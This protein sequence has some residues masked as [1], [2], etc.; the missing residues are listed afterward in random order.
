MDRKLIYW[1]LLAGGLAACSSPKEDIIRLNQVGYFPLQEKVAVADKVGV[2]DFRVVNAA[3]GEEIMEQPTYAAAPCA[4]SQKGR[5]TIDFSSLTEPGRYLLLAGGDTAVFEIKERPLASLA[6]ASLKAFYYQRAGMPIEET[7][8]GEWARPA[9][10]A[11]AEVQIHSSAESP[12]RKAGDVIASA[13]GWYDGSDYAKCVVSTAYSAGTML[14]AYR[15]FPDYFAG[16]NI[17]IPE[18]GNAT[19]D[20]LDEAHYALNWM[21]TMQDPGDGGVYHKLT[22]P[23]PE[24]FVKPSDC[25]QPRYIV[26]KSQAASLDF[27]AVM[28]QAALIFK[29]YAKDYPGFANTA[30]RAAE[31]AYKWAQDHAE[32][33]EQ[34]V[35]NANFDPDIT[36]A[37]YEDSETADEFFWAASELYYA[38][39]KEAYRNKAISSAKSGYNV[40]NWKDVTA[41]GIWAWLLPERENKL[42]VAETSLA[43][44]LKSYLLAYAGDIIKG[45]DETAFHAPYGDDEYDFFRGSL[46]ELCVGQGLSLAYAYLLSKDKKYLTNAYRNMD[47]LLGRNPLGYCYVTGFGTKSP[48]HPSHRLSATDGIDAPIPGFLVGGPN[49]SQNDAG[50]AHAS[51]LP[52]EAYSDAEA[53]AASN[54]VAIAWNAGLAALASALDAMSGE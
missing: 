49:P 38:T 33:Y 25:K 17:H 11:D 41:L 5:S 20:L 39:G 18:S 52:D 43:G 8:A 6:D 44:S 2:T 9:G 23:K 34:S 31:R 14:A 12:R 53:S 37:A 29:P 3:T 50:V 36:T 13:G 32:N 15:F 35:V 54:E 51:E 22:S 4:W 47:Y 26:A 30:L 46:G 28:A 7:Y 1:S 21:L 40:P 19:P 10:H 48:S 16:Q 27:A 24:D 42:D 45:S